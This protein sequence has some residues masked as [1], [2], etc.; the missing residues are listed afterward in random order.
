MTV[1]SVVYASAEDVGYLILS[2]IF[3]IRILVY[4]HVLL[5]VLYFI[6]DSWFTCTC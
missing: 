5:N 6:F 1:V 3:S 4:Y 2:P